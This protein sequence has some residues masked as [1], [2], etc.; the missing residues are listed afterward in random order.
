MSYSKKSENYLFKKTKKF[1]EKTPYNTFNVDKNFYYYLD[2][3]LN[4]LLSNVKDDNDLIVDVGCGMGWMSDYFKNINKKNVIS[5]DVSFSVL[6]FAKNRYNLNVIQANNLFLPIKS[7]CASLVLSSGVIH[8]T[9]N[10]YKSF[11]ELV[12]ILKSEGI[13][14]LQTYNKNSL[15]YLTYKYFGGLLRKPMEFYEPI[16]NVY[17]LFLLP[18][19]Y[20]AGLIR[21]MVL[22]KKWAN[23]SLSQ[24]WNHFRDFLLTPQASF[25]MLRELEKWFLDND[26]KILKY[27]MGGF[28][29]HCFILQKTDMSKYSA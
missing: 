26:M 1:Y 29:T 13:I 22:R 17:K 3:N 16:E 27:E 10:A 5:L 25:F 11:K 9:P 18:F 12:R 21:C 2:K 7:S 24:V 15:Y 8:H 14:L 23:R 20:L 4:L 19:F 6:T 28:G